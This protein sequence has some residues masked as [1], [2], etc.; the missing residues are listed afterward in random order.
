MDSQFQLIVQIVFIEM[1]F[2]HFIIQILKI[3]ELYLNHILQDM[4]LRIILMLEKYL[5]IINLKVI[6][7]YF[8]EKKIW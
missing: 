5:R 2:Q 4:I 3:R 1:F 6:K 7:L 8:L